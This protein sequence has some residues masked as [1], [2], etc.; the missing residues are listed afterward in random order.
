MASPV[1]ARLLPSPL[2]LAGPLALLVVGLV[3]CPDNHGRP[4][5]APDSTPDAFSFTDQSNVPLGATIDSNTITLAGTDDDAAISVTGGSYSIGCTGT[6]T[7][8][9][10]T[11]A[12]GATVCVRQ[13]S[14][15][16]GL[17]STNTVLT[18]GGVSDTFT[19]E[20]TP[21]AAD[22]AAAVLDCYDALADGAA[23][24]YSGFNDWFHGSVLGGEANKGG[25]AALQSEGNT[26]QRFEA[27]PTS[28]VVAAR[29]TSG[30]AGVAA[31]NTA[32]DRATD[33]LDPAVT[34]TD[35]DLARAEARFLR[36]LYYFELR[37]LFGRV[38]Y[39]DETMSP[40]VAAGVHNDVDIYPQI[41]ADFQFAIDHLPATQTDAFRPNL[42][43]A[44]AFLAKVHLYQQDFAAAE[45]LFQDVI[46]NGVTASNVRYGLLAQ[47]G[48]AFRPELYATS[49]EVVFAIR[50]ATT[51][52]PAT[53]SG[54]AGCCGFFQPSSDLVNS[55]RTDANGLPLIDGSYNNPFAA[56]RSDFGLASADP[57]TPDAGATDPRLDHNVG[58]RGIPYL[59]WGNHPGADWITDQA[60]GGPYSPKKYVRTAAQ[61]ASRGPTSPNQQLM[62]FADVL[63]MAA[64]VAA[65]RSSLEVARNYVNQV[66]AR[67]ANPAA[68][69]KDTGGGSAANYVIGLYNTPWTDQNFVRV[70]IR[71]ERKLELAGEGHRFF[72]LVRWGVADATL[73][74]YLSFEGT[75]LVAALGGAT[76]TP[77]KNE[78]Y[79]IPQAEI[80]AR[81]SGV[82]VQNPG[83]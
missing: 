10:G 22:V 50:T 14:A 31:C 65:E 16:S 48:D 43:A 30:Y 34:N 8:T 42:W 15:A 66:R 60:Y 21:L 3:G 68:W 29:W 33:S 79:P 52:T 37:R 39:V 58:R 38:P 9:A 6:F 61:V 20:T 11:I 74:A 27:T 24:P 83:Y 82:L 62:R 4:R 41:E 12:P 76:F 40:S 46:T 7:T 54:V 81:A 77:N 78:I 1:R 53:G 63:L 64:E 73:D 80:D 56:F 49:P 45:P 69:V 57:F 5:T 2:R 32:L 28:S 13:T 67:A 51:P 44:K 72:D 26:V 71:F 75:T 59:D 47:Y 19:S 25:T 55:H 17:A 35:R 18:I 23:G 70:A 36:G